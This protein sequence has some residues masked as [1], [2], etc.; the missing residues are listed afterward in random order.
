VFNN[1][2]SQ[3]DWTLFDRQ[4]GLNMYVS[5]FAFNGTKH[6]VDIKEHDPDLAEHAP[7]KIA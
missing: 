7:N 5:R 3:L 4:L 1:I 6:I 2:L